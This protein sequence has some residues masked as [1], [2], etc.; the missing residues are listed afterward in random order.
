MTA[1][2]AS[3]REPL[4]GIASC[5]NSSGWAPTFS[6]EIVGEQN[7]DFRQVEEDAGGLSQ[8]KQDFRVAAKM[9][10][11]LLQWLEKCHASDQRCQIVVGYTGRFGQA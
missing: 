6:P 11:I 9:E 3:E 8:G 1:A 5:R 7:G 10:E 2:A 4:S